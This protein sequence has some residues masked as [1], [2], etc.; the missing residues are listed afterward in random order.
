MAEFLSGFIAIVGRPNVGKSSLVN[1]LVGEKVAIVSNKPQTTRNR[2]MGVVDGKGYQMV[3]IDTPGVQRPKNKLGEFME[4]AVKSAVSDVDAICLVLDGASGLG[5]R[6]EE[7][8]RRIQPVG[9]P[10]LVVLNKCDI[11]EEEKIAA[12]RNELEQRGFAKSILTASALTGQGMD[13]LEQSLAKHL[14]EGPRYF[15]EGEITDM[16]EEFFC[17]EIVR[18]K[19]LRLLRDEIPHGIGVEIEKMMERKDGIVEIHAVIYCERKSHKSILIGKG[20]SMLKRIGSQARADL[21]EIFGTKVF[22]HLFVKVREDWRD[23]ATAL[24]DMGYR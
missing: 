21:E 7:L 23:S 15:P 13:V 12:L 5:P 18:E 19:A 4:G 22:L 6:D 8:I 11:A 2:I 16:P 10:I 20:G 1:A 3:L 9:V 14:V 24:K 17:K